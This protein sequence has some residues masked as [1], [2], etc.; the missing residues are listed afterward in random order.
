MMNI[1]MHP[2]RRDFILIHFL[3]VFKYLNG[4]PLEYMA[5]NVIL[6]KT[7]P[8]NIGKKVIQIVDPN[9]NIPEKSNI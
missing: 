8:K 4:Q 3:V 6:R 1:G 5:L 2:K 9:Q 7:E